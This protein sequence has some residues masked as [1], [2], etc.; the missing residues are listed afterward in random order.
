V[1]ARLGTGL[2]T[3]G[4]HLGVGQTASLLPWPVGEGVWLGPEG[5]T[6]LEFLTESGK[7]Q[8]RRLARKKPMT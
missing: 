6:D 3:L 5:V 7:L 1:V 4:L 8:K 2:A